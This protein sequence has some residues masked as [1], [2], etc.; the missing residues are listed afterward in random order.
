MKRPF[1]SPGERRLPQKAIVCLDL[2]NPWTFGIFGTR[3]DASRWIEQQN[4][5]GQLDWVFE[6]EL[7]GETMIYR[8]FEGERLWA[9][10]RGYVTFRPFDPTC[11]QAG[12]IVDVWSATAEERR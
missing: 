8:A 2:A 3:A 7:R 11:G 6:D 4:I 1:V 9:S 5:V 12:W 10:V